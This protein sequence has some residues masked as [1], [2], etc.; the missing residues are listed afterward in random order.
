MIDPCVTTFQIEW[1][2]THR[3]ISTGDV[4][5]QLQEDVG[6]SSDS[7][8]LVLR[9]LRIVASGLTES[10]FERMSEI[11]PGNQLLENLRLIAAAA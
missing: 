3:R 2:K 11:W 1:N 8:F 6:P 10:D 9:K 4:G 7:L 5:T